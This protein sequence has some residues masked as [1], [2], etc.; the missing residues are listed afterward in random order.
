MLS[1]VEMPSGA[2]FSHP[3]R[4]CIGSRASNEHLGTKGSDQRSRNGVVLAH[5]EIA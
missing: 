2:K 5:Q 1:R 4:L 3:Y